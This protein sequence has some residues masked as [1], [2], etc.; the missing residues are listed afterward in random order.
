MDRLK[1]SQ[2]TLHPDSSCSHTRTRDLDARPTTYF[3]YLFV[4]STPS[5]AD[6][7]LARSL[8]MPEPTE[9][10]L[11]PS[12]EFMLSGGDTA[13]RFNPSHRRF[14]QVFTPNLRRISL[15]EIPPSQ[16]DDGC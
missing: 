2:F 12:P 5:F 15:L 9:S 6:G 8:T 4:H 11:V 13:G 14:R 16:C 1:F 7:A 3:A 10:R